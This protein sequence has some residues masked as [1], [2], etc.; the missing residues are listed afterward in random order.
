MFSIFSDGKLRWKSK[1][2]GDNS[3]SVF[4]YAVPPSLHPNKLVYFINTNSSALFALS[5]KD[6]SLVKSYNITH[7]LFYYVQPPI[8]V[9]SKVL[10]LTRFGVSPY[11]ECHALVEVLQLRL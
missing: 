4:N 1:Q 9:G 3:G 5:T 11:T 7:E 6:G 8:V 10:Y 2:F